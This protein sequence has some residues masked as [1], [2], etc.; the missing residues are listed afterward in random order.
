MSRIF[1]AAAC[2]PTSTAGRGQPCR[3]LLTSQLSWASV[4]F[5]WAQSR[6]TGGQHQ[7]RETRK[8]RAVHSSQERKMPWGTSK[9][10]H[11]GGW[12]GGSFLPALQTFLSLTPGPMP[13]SLTLSP[14]AYRFQ[15][16][17]HQWNFQISG[18]QMGLASSK[19]NRPTPSYS[20][21]TQNRGDEDGTWFHLPSPPFLQKHLQLQGEPRASSV[22]E[23]IRHV[24]SLFC[25]TAEPCLK[26]SLLP[27]GYISTGL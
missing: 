23:S 7:A 1:Y 15:A 27:K 17:H 25:H 19:W 11:V 20:R 9:V 8:G 10:W 16:Q 26:V 2:L 14:M 3:S 5:V 12:G 24:K 22:K 21:V 6:D 4:E 18:T 13:S